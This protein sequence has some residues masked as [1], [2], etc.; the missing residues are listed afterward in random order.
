MI[1]RVRRD[2]RSKQT[3]PSYFARM[4]ISAASGL[5]CGGMKERRDVLRDFRDKARVGGRVASRE[6]E[7]NA[8]EKD[9]NLARTRTRPGMALGAAKIAVDLHAYGGKG[10]EEGV[11]GS[12]HILRIFRV[13]RWIRLVCEL[14]LTNG[15]KSSTVSCRT[16]SGARWT[17]VSKQI[18]PSL[19]FIILTEKTSRD[20]SPTSIEISRMRAKHFVQR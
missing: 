14:W 8:A 4:K 13:I 10:H 1:E 19:S 6:S 20:V 2:R 11:L 17:S 12:C 18:D 7:T 16:T 9:P 15:K 5:V 3:P